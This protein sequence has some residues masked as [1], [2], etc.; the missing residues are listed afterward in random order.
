MSCGVAQCPGSAGRK[1]ERMHRRPGR[2][3]PGAVGRGRTKA[4]FLVQAEEAPGETVA[5]Q[6]HQA[7]RALSSANT[8]TGSQKHPSQTVYGAR[9][10]V[11]LT[12]KASDP[13]GPAMRSQQRARAHAASSQLLHPARAWG[14]SQARCVLREVPRPKGHSRVSHEGAASARRLHPGSSARPLRRLLPGRDLGVAPKRTGGFADASLS[15]GGQ[16]QQQDWWV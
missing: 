15:P 6:E 5:S 2:P 3:G 1:Y 12:G 8:Q 16:S 10:G 11:S 14:L 9:A 7:L 4:A 13:R